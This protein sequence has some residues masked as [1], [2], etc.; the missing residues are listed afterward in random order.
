MVVF[1][2]FEYPCKC[3]CL[4]LE[5]SSDY[6]LDI[7]STSGVIVYYIRSPGSPIEVVYKYLCIHF[8]YYF[9]STKIVLNERKRNHSISSYGFSLDYDLRSCSL[10]N[11][12]QSTRSRADCK[13]ILH[14][15]SLFAIGSINKNNVIRKTAVGWRGFGANESYKTGRRLW[16]TNFVMKTKKKY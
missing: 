6:Y 9:L 1:F 13:Y 10:R 15:V 11:V 14:I 16:D 5:V 4:H 8:F 3:Y 12:G 2:L 7:I